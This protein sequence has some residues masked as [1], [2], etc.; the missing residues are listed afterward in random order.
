MF[1]VCVDLIRSSPLAQTS[2]VEFVPGRAVI[3]AK[4]RKRVKYETKCANIGYEFLPLSFS[5]F[6]N[7][8]R[9][10]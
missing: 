9:I 4:Q 1:D 3:K 6:E 8:R 10:R 7:L 5:S 2:M